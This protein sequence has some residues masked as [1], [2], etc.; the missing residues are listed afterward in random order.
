MAW[1]DHSLLSA[2]ARVSAGFRTLFNL[3][4]TLA[5]LRG[6]EDADRYWQLALKHAVDGNLQALLD[7]QTHV[8]LESQGL[9]NAPYEKR[10]EEISKVLAESLSIRTARQQ[11]DEFRAR[12]AA[13]RVDVNPFSIRCRFALRFGELKNDQDKT[14]AR[15]DTVRV[16]FN[17]PFRPFVLA[18]TSI[19]QEGLDFHTWCHAVM[20]WNLPSNPVDLEQREGRVHRYKGHAVRKNVA[21]RF[22]LN[23]LAHGWSRSGDPW[24]FLFNLAADGEKQTSDIVPYWVYE[25]GSDPAKVERRV[26]L[27]PYSREVERLECL[28]RSLAM[29]RLVFGQPRQDDLLAHLVESMPEGRARQ[30]TLRWALSLVPPEDGD[31]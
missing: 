28:K 17:S 30:A 5:L 26:P 7:E 31:S 4:E 25:R 19:G 11:V 22:G 27:I 21:R 9:R 29:Y 6:E 8:L 20:H 12:P 23:A 2:A 24:E 16:A 15:A 13:R 18:S 10:V 3:P 14:V 1:H